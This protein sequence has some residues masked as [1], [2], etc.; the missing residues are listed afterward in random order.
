MR[1][2]GVSGHEGTPIAAWVTMENPMKLDEVEKYLSI[3]ILHGG[4]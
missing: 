4:W 1:A 2:M 3:V